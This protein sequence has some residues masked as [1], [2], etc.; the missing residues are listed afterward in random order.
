MG[1]IIYQAEITIPGGIIHADRSRFA[2]EYVL[3]LGHFGLPHFQG[4]NA[5]INQFEEGDKKVITA[6][7][8]G[9]RLALIIY[10]GWDKLDS[11]VHTNRN[12]EPN[13][14]TVIYA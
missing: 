5:V 8:P 12:A 1:Y 11:L 4:E 9:R 3:T 6:S 2:F 13:E 7:I 14:S 10:S